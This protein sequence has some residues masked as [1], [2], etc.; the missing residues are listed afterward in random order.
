[1]RLRSVFLVKS[2]MPGRLLVTNV[3]QRLD[4]GVG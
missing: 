3:V 4:D 1:M 2:L